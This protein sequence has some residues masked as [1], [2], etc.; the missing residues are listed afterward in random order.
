[1][2]E[3]SPLV[4]FDPEEPSAVIRF[5]VPL[6]SFYDGKNIID[7]QI[8]DRDWRREIAEQI[9][10]QGSSNPSSE[11]KPKPLINKPE[12]RRLSES[13]RQFINN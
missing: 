9:R 1:M 2:S 10:A 13:I 8:P 6:P 5:D 3:G 12:I 7:L 4:T 11:R